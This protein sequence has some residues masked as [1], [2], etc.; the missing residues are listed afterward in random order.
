LKS[1]KSVL[2]RVSTGSDSDLVSDQHGDIPD[3]FDYYGSTRSLP[4]PVLPDPSAIATF[5]AKPAK[6]VNTTRVERV[7][8]DS[9]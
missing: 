2:D 8:P 3:D 4:L 7:L 9:R 6:T 5:E 1:Q